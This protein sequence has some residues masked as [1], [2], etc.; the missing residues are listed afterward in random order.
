MVT[1]S[2]LIVLVGCKSRVSWELLKGDCAPT[3]EEIW[4]DGVDQDCDGNDADQDGDGFVPDAYV[5]A[6]PDWQ[7]TLSRHAE[8][9]PGDCWD[10][11]N[12]DTFLAGA[13]D[14]VALAHAAAASVLAYAEHTQGRALSHLHDLRVL[15][16]G[17]WNGTGSPAPAAAQRVRLPLESAP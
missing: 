6:F 9:R 5:A 7:T 13:T 4:Y 2:L 10:D 11:P 17:W 3:G 15:E 16:P 12:D 14:D 8:L 1:L